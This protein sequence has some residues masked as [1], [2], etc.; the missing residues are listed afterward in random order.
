[1][2]GWVT[3]TDSKAPASEVRSVLKKCS[4][5]ES[6]LCPA[7]THSHPCACS[8]RRTRV[9]LPSRYLQGARP[10]ARRQLTISPAALPH[11]LQEHI[12]NPCRKSH[13]VS[14]LQAVSEVQVAQSCPTLCD[15]GQNT[16]V[17][18]LSLLRDRT[19]VSCTAGRSS[20]SWATREAYAVR[21]SLNPLI[22][23]DP[24][25]LSLFRT[26]MFTQC[27]SFPKQLVWV[28]HRR[29]KA[30]KLVLYCLWIRCQCLNF[31]CVFLLALEVGNYYYYIYSI[32][33]AEP[34][35][36]QLPDPELKPALSLVCSS[37]TR[38]AL[39]AWLREDFLLPWKGSSPEASR[40]PT[41]SPQWHIPP[42]LPLPTSPRN[43]G[44]IEST[45]T[46]NSSKWWKVII[47]IHLGP[48]D[49]EKWTKRKRIWQSF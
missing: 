9:Q 44:T 41:T 8:V 10:P 37:D 45:P 13:L 16:G 26:E 42:K 7:Y 18:G 27:D 30:T 40:W 28:I 31:L 24:E 22:I 21:K 20:T 25:N 35:G 1:M 46:S 47:Q 38:Q 15:P 32:K 43:T 48:R 36:R 23:E 14:A 19:Q 12:T 11:L 17:S 2:K 29:L 3:Q 49:S 5:T 34:R 33:K 39:W 6:R 4:C